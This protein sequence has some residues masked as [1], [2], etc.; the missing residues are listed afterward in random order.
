MRD[1]SVI[2]TSQAHHRCQLQAHLGKNKFQT[3]VLLTVLSRC[4]P[5]G[6]DRSSE[7]FRLRPTRAK[8][9]IL[10]VVPRGSFKET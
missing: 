7:S 9:E 3:V 5:H 8:I 4:G 2:Q 1:R 6:P 10:F